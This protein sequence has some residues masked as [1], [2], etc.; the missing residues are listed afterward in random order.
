MVNEIFKSIQL[1]M[2]KIIEHYQ[3][4]IA[5]IRTGRA[6]PGLVE[7]IKVDYYGSSS[8]L[9]NIAQISTPESQVI[10]IQPFDPSSLD[11]ITKAITSSDL[12]FTPNNDGQVIRINIPP[13]T[14]DRRKEYV[15]LAH[16]MIED[17]RI[18]IRN[19]RRDANDNLK[20]INKQ[21]E[22]SDDNLKRALD[23]VQEITDKNIKEL[24]LILANKE[25][26]IL[27]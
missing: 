11:L 19:A 9:K 3:N 17:G 25:K 15:K 16:N 7:S 23:D 4:G 24:N 2:T 12:G 1:K 8:P 18:A 26:E 21:N 5:S 10:V 20:K 27:N 6:N 13:L 14:E 22:L